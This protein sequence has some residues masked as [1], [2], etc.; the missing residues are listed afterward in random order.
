[1]SYSNDFY[2]MTIISLVAFP[3]VMM[4]RHTKPAA[5]PPSDEEAAAAPAE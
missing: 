4:M 5:A 2:V 3:F 1:M